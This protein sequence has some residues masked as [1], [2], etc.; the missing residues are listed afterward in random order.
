MASLVLDLE[1]EGASI[2]PDKDLGS[3]GNVDSPSLMH[4]EPRDRRQ[5]GRASIVATYAGMEAQRRFDPSNDDG[6]DDDERQAFWISSY[7]QVFPRY[8]SCVG[9]DRHCAYLERLRGEAR[10]LIRRHWSEVEMVAGLLLV[11]KRLDRDRL[12][13]LSRD[14]LRT[15]KEEEADNVK[16]NA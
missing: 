12:K 1:M 10:R 5:V 11:H 14:H 3:L 4:Y 9:D 7:Y 13:G 2:L 16:R 6:G 8:I 15:P